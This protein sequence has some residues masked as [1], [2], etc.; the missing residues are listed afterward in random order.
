MQIQFPIRGDHADAIY[1]W[2]MRCGHCGG[3]HR[4]L[5]Q[6]TREWEPCE[7]CGPEREA[8]RRYGVEVEEYTS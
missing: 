3:S 1:R 4:F 6:E 8:M 2:I 7:F 5:N